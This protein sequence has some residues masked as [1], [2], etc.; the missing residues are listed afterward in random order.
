MVG[1]LAMNTADKAPQA[2][3]GYT[4][5]ANLVNQLPETKSALAELDTLQKQFNDQFN[6]KVETYQSKL[7]DYEAKKENLNEVIRAD[8]ETELQSL[9][10][11]IGKFQQTAQQAYQA[12]DTEL[13]TPIYERVQTAIDA[14]AAEYGYTHIVATDANTSV[15]VYADEETNVEELIA[16]KLKEPE[17]KAD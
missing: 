7:K 6:E 14:V 12:K 1:M 8:K 17:S 3:I 11:S 2:R 10:E 4:S 13:M 5:M 9:Q 15:F 16:Y